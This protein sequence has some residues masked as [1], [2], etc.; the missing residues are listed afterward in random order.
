MLEIKSESWWLLAVPPFGAIPE[1][2]GKRFDSGS[3][4]KL[5]EEVEVLRDSKILARRLFGHLSGHK[6]T[7][8]SKTGI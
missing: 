3:G 2:D 8:F 4:E 1:A 7:S 5:I 6:A